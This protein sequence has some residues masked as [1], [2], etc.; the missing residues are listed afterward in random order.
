MMRS[1]LDEGAASGTN[2]SQTLARGIAVLRALRAEPKGMSIAELVTML[3]LH[4]SIVT[5]LLFTLE[6]ERLVERTEDKRYRLGLD[7]IGL[8]KAV[9]S[10]LR[11]L[12]AP[13]LSALAASLGATTILVARKGDD[14]VVVSVVEPPHGD[15]HLSFRLGSRH[16]LTQGAEGMAILAGRAP[17]EG[18]RAEI[19]AARSTGYVVSYGEIQPGTWGLAAPVIVEGAANASVG[20]IAAAPLEEASAAAAVRVA[21]AEIA[22]R[23]AIADV[24]P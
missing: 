8:G 11:D 14:A 20:V 5:R 9:R 17:V 24:S 19:T 23:L 2:G 13:I 22:G 4:R 12:T 6:A 10:E 18:E 15:L 3:G 21:A 1:M 7:L 16:P